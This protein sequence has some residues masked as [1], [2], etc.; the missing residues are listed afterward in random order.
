MWVS[1]GVNATEN[2]L[3]ITVN[4]WELVLVRYFLASDQEGDASDIYAIEVSPRTLAL[5][6]GSDPSRASEAEEA[7]RTALL[8]D[9]VCLL[10]ALKYGPQRRA[11][12]DAP[13]CFAPLAMTL[14]IDLLL[15]GATETGNQFRSKL[16]DWLRIDRK[17]SDLS[18][19]KLMWDALNQWLH[20]R[21]KH[22]APFRQIVLPDPGSWHHIGYTR[23]LSFPNRAD[24]RAIIYA[25]A[26]VPESDLSNPVRVI[27]AVAQLEGRRSISVG[28]KEA[29]VDFV[30][31]YYSQRRA[32]A[33]HRFWRLVAQARV[34]EAGPRLLATLDISHTADNEREF[35]V[36]REPTKE[37][38]V[39]WTLSAALRDK[40][41][42]T[43][44]N[45]GP[46]ISRGLL[47]FKQIG[48]GHWTAESNLKK[49]QTRVLIAFDNRYSNILHKQLGPVSRYEQWRLTLDPIDVIRVEDQLRM[50]SIILD[51]SVQLFRPMA[52]NGIRVYGAW[53]GLP[54]FL[55]SIDAD[56]AELQVTPEEDHI[57]AFR[58]TK[59]ATISLASDAPIAGAYLVE[60]QLLQHEHRPPWR[61]R[62]QFV[63]RAKPHLKLGKT[64][65][66]LSLLEDWDTIGTTRVISSLPCNIGWGRSHNAMEWLLEALYAS[67]ANGW[68]E[69]NLVTLISRADPD[70]SLAPWRTLRMLQ[71]GSVIEPRLR[72]GWK[73][74]VW[75]LIPPRIVVSWAKDGTPIVLA[76]GALCLHLL[77]AF[78]ITTKGMGGMPFRIPG[79]ARWSVPITG[80]LDIDP[81]VLAC[82]L[83]WDLVEQI[84]SPSTTPLAL[85]ETRRI[86]TNYKIAFT[87]CW[88]ERRF[89]A[90]KTAEGRV[91]LTQLSHPSAADHDVYRVQHAEKRW[92]FLSRQAAIVAAHSAARIPLLA[93][94]DDRIEVMAQDGG[95]PDKLAIALRRRRLESGGFTNNYYGYPATHEDAIWLAKLL[96]G[97]IVG[98]PTHTE[99]S[100]GEMLSRS[101]R[102]SSTLRVQWRSG[103]LIL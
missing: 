78:E 27:Q 49:C 58:I 93:F 67:G 62:L 16:A 19:I 52:S 6:C 51:S 38:H 74:R 28:L 15:D 31:S 81:S 21:I 68:D 5:A 101:R 75:T 83:G 24:I 37:T 46:A 12:L 98:T 47:F 56:T 100:T 32:I 99:L 25:L 30:Q 2:Q 92:H 22:G 45:L 94:V 53:L 77:E 44:T 85:A 18:G 39:H 55:P 3:P 10:R 23:R 65:Q 11:S 20:T 7:F 84:E 1:Q 26:N 73:G 33:D 82:R 50:C 103:R 34:V 96:P 79:A 4:E 80:A 60:P 66:T 13:N 59:A 69:S 57:A 102:S 91:Q 95:L 9:Q 54:G 40:V 76:E 63:D 90:L 71:E 17:F 48:L 35:R 41:L 97:C 29:Y 43:T 88:D 87:W 14:L 72:N 64:R 89:K 36:I 42:T 61:L 86:A 70:T 8:R